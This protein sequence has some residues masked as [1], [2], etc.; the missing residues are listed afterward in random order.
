MS[1]FR[2][3]LRLANTPGLG[4]RGTA[5]AERIHADDVRLRGRLE[6]PTGRRH[7]CW[8]RIT[9]VDGAV[10]SQK[11]GTAPRGACRFKRHQYSD[12]RSNVVAL[13]SASVLIQIL[14][15]SERQTKVTERR[16]EDRCLTSARTSRRAACRSPSAPKHASSA[17]NSRNRNISSWERRNAK[18][19]IKTAWRARELHTAF[20]GGSFSISQYNTSVRMASEKLSKSTGFWM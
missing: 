16:M 19:K 2:S 8:W 9:P 17:A 10:G 7:P 11:K 1:R 6:S 14:V 12:G 18:G 5:R 20:G 15:P 13:R 3:T 4:R